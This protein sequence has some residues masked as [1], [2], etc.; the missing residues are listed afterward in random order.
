MNILAKLYLPNGIDPAIDANMSVEL[1]KE[2]Q[3][4]FL[5]REV[6]ADELELNDEDLAALGYSLDTRFVVGKELMA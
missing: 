4:K 1:N 3:K 5:N 6:S 2:D